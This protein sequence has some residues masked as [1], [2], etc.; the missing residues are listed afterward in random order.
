MRPNPFNW[1]QLLGFDVDH[2]ARLSPLVT[3]NGLIGQQIP[4]PC[5]TIDLSQHPVV[6]PGVARALAI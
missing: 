1:G 6:D 5:Q 2:V 4:E 3:V